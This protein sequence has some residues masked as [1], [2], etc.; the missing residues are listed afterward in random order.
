MNKRRRLGRKAHSK[1]VLDRYAVKN[2]TDW[3]T[4]KKELEDQWEKL[5]EELWDEEYYGS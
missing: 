2:P 3:Q 4:M 5:R 1:E